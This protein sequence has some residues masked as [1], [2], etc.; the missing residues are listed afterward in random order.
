MKHN[1]LWL[2]LETTGLDPDKGRPLEFA[3]VLCE[4]GPDDDFAIVQSYTSPIHWSVP[5]L[6][7]LDIDPKVMAMHH[8][9]G[10]WADVEAS[11]VGILEVDKFLCSLAGGTSIVIAG[12]SVHFDRNWCKAWFCDFYKLVSHRI[13]DVRTLMTACEV[14]LPPAEVPTWTSRD[15]HRA[16][17]DILATIADARLARAA[18]RG[19]IL[20]TLEDARLARAALRVELDEANEM[21]T[22]YRVARDEAQWEAR[23]LRQEVSDLEDETPD[24]GKPVCPQCKAPLSDHWEDGD[25]P[26]FCSPCATWVEPLWA[27]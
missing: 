7:K 24:P 27:R 5:E 22:Q 23:K 13:F 20:A 6:G 9:N 16:L 18:L 26:Y 17:P 25:R 19:D 11:T 4:D 21:A 12:A 2:D 15:K 1:F 8:Y 14:W 10:L 3:A